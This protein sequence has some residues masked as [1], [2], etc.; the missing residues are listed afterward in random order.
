MVRYAQRIAQQGR[1]TLSDR[2]KPAAEPTS[3]PSESTTPQFSIDLGWIDTAG[4]TR[5]WVLLNPHG[6]QMAE[7]CTK[8]DALKLAAILNRV[9]ENERQ[10]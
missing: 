4:R 2:N 3:V 9:L 7:I 8:R 6:T 1:Q 10:K 5:T